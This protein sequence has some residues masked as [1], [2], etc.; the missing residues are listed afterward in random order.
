MYEA[1][2]YLFPLKEQV[3]HIIRNHLDKDPKLRRVAMKL[4]GFPIIRFSLI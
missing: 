4:K 3:Y 1:T 2:D